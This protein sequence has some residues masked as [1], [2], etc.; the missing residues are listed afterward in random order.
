[1]DQQREIMQGQLA[2]AQQATDAATTGANAAKLAAET[3]ERALKL[4]DR[5]D[6]LV[7]NV[8]V[9]LF[10]HLLGWNSV[11]TAAFK[12]Y[13]RT[14]ATHVAVRCYLELTPDADKGVSAV[15]GEV[16]IVLGAGETFTIQLPTLAWIG[17]AHSTAAWMD[18]DTLDKINHSQVLLWFNAEISYKD[19]FDIDRPTHGVADLDMRRGTFSIHYKQAR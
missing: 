13:G 4:V 18:D 7:Q 16:P 17:C 12:N 6:I 10:D 19:V 15:M 8:N 2:A 14:R 9:T 3:T 1:M 11:I 5:A